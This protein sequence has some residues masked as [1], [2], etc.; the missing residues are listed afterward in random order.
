MNARCFHAQAAALYWRLLAALVGREPAE[1][2]PSLLGSG[3]F[4]AALLAMSVQIVAAAHRIV[5]AFR[6]SDCI[7]AR[8]VRRRHASLR[9]TVP[10]AD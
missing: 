10:I 3:T 2:V 9:E 7:D 4:H 6:W 1:R 8:S 5:S